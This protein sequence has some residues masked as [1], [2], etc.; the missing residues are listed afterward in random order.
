MY[1][2]NGIN[3]MNKALGWRLLRSSIPHPTIEMRLTSPARTGRDGIASI[4]GSRA[5]IAPTFTVATGDAGLED[6]LALFTS[7]SLV[8]AHEN[9]PSRTM[10]GRLL[11]ATP[12]KYHPAVGKYEFS[13]IVEVPE[14][15]WRGAEETTTKVAANNAGAAL[16]L[17]DSI[18]APVQDAIVRIEGPITNPQVVDTSGAYFVLDGPLSAGQYLRYHSNS[19]RAWT[20]SSNT[21]TGGTEVSGLITSG[22]PRG[23]FE[24]TPRYPTPGNVKIRNARL[25][26]TQTTQTSG[27]GFQVRGRNGFII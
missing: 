15:M 21:W 18:S 6:L 13:F 24:I 1:L 8:I 10:T 2:V 23:L 22:G 9:A 5:E 19:G 16:T 26:L 14:G 3:L 20:T 4:P 27:A 11:S 7:P 17:F 12:T 25:A